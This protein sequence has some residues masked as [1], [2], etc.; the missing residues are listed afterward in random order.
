MQLQESIK[1]T[2]KAVLH[3]A[4]RNAHRRYLTLASLLLLVYSV[5]FMGHQWQNLLKGSSDFILNFGFIALV[6]RNLY[7]QRE[8]LRSYKALS[9]DR[10]IGY[11]L[12]LGGGMMFLAVRVGTTSISLQA[13]AAMLI[14]VGM[15]ASTWGLEFFTRFWS[16]AMLVLVALYPNIGYVAIRVFRFFTSKDSLEHLMAQAGSFSLNLFQF[17]ALAEG[18]YVKFP[19]GAV[20]VASGCSGFDMALS[21]VGIAF[22]M[23][24][25]MNASRLRTAMVMFVGWAL[26]MLFNVPR[27]M[28]LAIASVYWG[29]ESF[30]FW[31]GPI[32][33]QIFSCI[34]FTV[35]YYIAMW[36]IEYKS[37]PR[38][39]A[40]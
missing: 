5:A 15:A 10:L 20:E 19:E 37:Q 6:V 21:T 35:Y 9:D 30:D 8:E 3:A 40:S 14:V 4:T 12:M 28:M 7:R 29:K 18:V 25:F 17:Q 1:I 39:N 22:L 27:I 2:P 16:A 31:H 11:V 32:G 26:A 13:L 33:G 34:L 36:I 38:K 23:G 24:Q